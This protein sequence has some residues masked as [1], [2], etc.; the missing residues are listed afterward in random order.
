MTPVLW[1]C[2]TFKGPSACEY[3]LCLGNGTAGRVL[4]IPALFDE[5]N[6]LRRF[7]V[8]TMR[9]LAQAGI[10][11]VLPDLP[12]CNESLQPLETQTPAR[13]AEAIRM[14]AAHFEVDLVLGLRGG[15]LFTPAD[16]P[17][18][19]YAPTSGA[20]IL[21]QLLRARIVSAR[22][23]GYSE[24][25]DALAALALRDGITLTGYRLGARF[26]AQFETLTPA[27]DTPLIEQATLPGGGLWRRAEPSED[28]TQA[29][30]LA[31][32]V[33]DHLAGLAK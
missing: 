5:G 6:K 23:A 21:R 15:A 31:H 30:A 26:F 16:L 32:M 12:G 18:L 11:S 7:T 4:I 20:T 24:T 14:C 3:A 17:A 9:A 1:P 2:P 33:A 22:E 27:P 8:E 25:R 19:H 13:W 29:R 10:A 28:P